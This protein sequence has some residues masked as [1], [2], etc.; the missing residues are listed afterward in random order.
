MGETCF[1][2]RSGP[3]CTPDNANLVCT[4]D[5]FSITITDVD[6]YG[7]AEAL[8]DE[9]KQGY[10]YVGDPGQDCKAQFENNGITGDN[11][12]TIVGVWDECGVNP[13]NESPSI[14]YTAAVSASPPMI[15]IEDNGLK[16]W[17]T[18][19]Q[20]KFENFRKYYTTL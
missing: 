13:V 15:V 11:E 1:G 9:Q 14:T 20:V 3:P 8:T 16:I 18:Q 6:M 10:V 12:V 17:L 4:T 5:G 19:T 2:S 7:D